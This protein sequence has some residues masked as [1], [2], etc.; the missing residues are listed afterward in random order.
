M[1]AVNRLSD[2]SLLLTAKDAATLCRVS[3]PTWWRMVAA[4]RTPEAIKPS[5][6]ATRWRRSDLEAWV[7][8]GCSAP[9][10]SRSVAQ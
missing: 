1:K 2:A 9:S 4:G 7:A 8:A 3:L 6:G 5:P 10:I